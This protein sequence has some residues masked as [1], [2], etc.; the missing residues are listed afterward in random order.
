MNTPKAAIEFVNVSF[1]Y[2]SADSLALDNINFK[3]HAG[4]FVVL[5]G[6]SGSGK[7]TCIRVLNGL[8]PNFY[9]GI[10]S[11]QVLLYGQNIIGKSTHELARQV[12]FVFQNPDNQLLMNDVENEIAFGLENIGVPTEQIQARIDSALKIVG[13]EYLRGRS[14]TDLSGGEKQK[15]AIAAVLALE[16]KIIVL[17]EP[18]AE[19]DPPS[20]EAI[21]HYLHNLHAQTQ[22]TVILIEHR[23]DRVIHHANRIIIMENGRVIRN[24]HPQSLFQTDINDMGITIPPIIKL[25]WWFRNHNFNISKIPLTLSDAKDEFFPFLSQ[26]PITEK[27]NRYIRTPKD[28]KPLVELDGVSFEYTKNKKIF[29]NLS[30]YAY[31]GEFIGIIGYNGSGKTTLLKLINRLLRPTTGSVKINQKDITKFSI[32][33]IAHFVGYIFQNPGWQ[34]Y[35]DTLEEEFQFILRNLNFPANDHSSRISRYLDQFQ[36]NNLRKS[37]PRYLSWGQQQKAALASVLM[38]EPQI[39]L[40]DEPTHGMDE[41]QKQHFMQFLHDYAKSGHLIFFITHDIETIAQYATRILFISEGKT[42][43]D[44][45]PH[46]IFPQ[47]PDFLPQLQQLV[48]IS[49]EAP[50]NLIT[51]KDLEE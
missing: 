14:L 34:F 36:L 8:I 48:R 18:T 11:G 43:Y 25:G 39:L 51:M 30:L 26:L 32:A 10:I 46:L 49:P 28:L 31:P 41:R 38:I 6:L 20:T 7:S 3:I 33:E 42:K 27:N 24:E 22:I 15:I 4:E 19:L 40:L 12:G 2:Q 23:L 47:L 35:H 17:D 16:P 13:I 29:N 45:E 5:T 9:G 44:G 37:Y 50:K 21:L 1:K